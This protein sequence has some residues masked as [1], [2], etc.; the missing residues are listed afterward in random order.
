MAGPF[1]MK[2]FSG[3]GNSPVK[4]G[5]AYA[6]QTKMKK[7]GRT[8]P[9][10]SQRKVIEEGQELSK[11]HT[12]KGVTGFEQDIVNPTKDA[13]LTAAERTIERGKTNIH[14]KL[15]KA[16]KKVKDYFTKR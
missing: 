15:R 10:P 7:T 11:G 8:L 2:G 14:K 1:K 5:K 3:F 12:L 4:Q 13:F 9:H 6:S 16:G